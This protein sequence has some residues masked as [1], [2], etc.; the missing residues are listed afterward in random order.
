MVSETK[1]FPSK[2]FEKLKNRDYRKNG[3]LPVFNHKSHKMLENRY[4]LVFP[5]SR[6]FDFLKIFKLTAIF[7]ASE[8]IV[9]VSLATNVMVLYQKR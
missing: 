2:V 4:F 8:N 6:F 1:S 7:L 9:T 5:K 3:N